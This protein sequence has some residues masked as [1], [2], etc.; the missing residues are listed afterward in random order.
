MRD[1]ADSDTDDN[2]PVAKKREVKFTEK[3]K[4]KEIK[5]VGFVIEKEIKE[6][7]N[8]DDL[9]GGSQSTLTQNSMIE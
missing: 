3:A 2:S 6:K 9:N 7:M 4:C 1:N 8:E 5:S